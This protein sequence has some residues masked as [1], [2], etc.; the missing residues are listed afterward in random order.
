VTLPP[1]PS[2]QSVYHGPCVFREGIWFLIT[3]VV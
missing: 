1:P 2:P 3:C